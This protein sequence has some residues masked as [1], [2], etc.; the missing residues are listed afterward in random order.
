LHRYALPARTVDRL[1]IVL[2][3]DPSTLTGR[4][5]EDLEPL[6]LGVDKMQFLADGK[7]RD[8]RR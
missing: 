8:D 6:L 2:G 3:V 5:I 7:I 1:D 4:G